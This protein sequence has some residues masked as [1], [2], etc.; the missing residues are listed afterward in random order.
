MTACKKETA[1]NKSCDT[2]KKA[3]L[4]KD[5]ELMKTE[6]NQICDKIASAPSPAGVQTLEQQQDELVKILNTCIT[7]ESFCYFCIHTNPGQSEIRL[8]TSGVSR[9]ID[10]SYT[11]TQKL[12]FVNMHD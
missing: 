12:V 11:S 3:L 7:A 9:I 1:Q 6:I 2:I 5:I 8:T 10:I 4:S